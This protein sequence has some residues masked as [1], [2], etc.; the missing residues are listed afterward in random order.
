MRQ[1][2]R[3]RG[4][5]SRQAV[6]RDLNVHVTREGR[7]RRDAPAVRALR[8]SFGRSHGVVHAEH[9]QRGLRGP[10]VLLSVIQLILQDRRQLGEPLAFEVRRRR[11]ESLRDRI[12]DPCRLVGIRSAPGDPHEIALGGGANA[13]LVRQLQRGLAGGRDREVHAATRSHAAARRYPDESERRAHR[14]P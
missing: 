3:D 11:D 10:E 14:L 8:R 5:I 6:E 1:H 13:Q 4:A 2:L 7:V 12:G 9:S